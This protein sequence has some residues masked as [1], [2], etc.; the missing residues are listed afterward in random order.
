MPET[1][2]LLL[3]AMAILLLIV[4]LGLMTGILTT[5][6]KS[7]QAEGNLNNLQA[8]GISLKAGQSQNYLLTSPK[9]WYIVSFGPGNGLSECIK[10]SCLCFCT[11]SG[12]LTG[13]RKCS[14]FNRPVVLSAGNY[15][16]PTY[17]SNLKFELSSSG[18]QYILS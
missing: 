3:S 16:L 14:V 12:C 10:Q 8:I 2:R 13:S 1:L 7:R 5:A 4:F 18:D 11:D 9:G 15:F 6:A 17:P